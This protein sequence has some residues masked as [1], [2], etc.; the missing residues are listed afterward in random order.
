M[1]RTQDQSLNGEISLVDLTVTFVRRRKI[2]YLVFLLSSL[3]GMAYTVLAK[4]TYSY[5]SLFQGA[6]ENSG[7]P[8]V[9][10]ESAIA[11]LENQWLP[12]VRE[13][14]ESEHGGFPFE[15][16]F[17]NPKSTQLIRITSEAGKDQATALQEVH[18]QLIHELKLFQ[19]EQLDGKKRRLKRQIDSVSKLI[20]S[21]QASGFDGE[22]L[23]AAIGEKIEAD[24]DGLLPAKILLVGRQSSDEVGPRRVLI[25]V[26]AIALGAMLGLFA[27]FFWEFMMV[28]RKQLQAPHAT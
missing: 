10:P 1:D 23:A 26:L 16:F 3:A 17:E 18:E 12:Q 22:A 5:V 20:D 15:V 2:F 13:K 11:K 7:E 27:A 4:S 14:Y 8:M 6:M 21:L 9:S 19:Q 25:V 24:A 28:V